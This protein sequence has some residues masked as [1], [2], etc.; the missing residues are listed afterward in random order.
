MTRNFFGKAVTFAA[1]AATVVVANSA[2]AQSRLNFV[3]SVNVS[4][5][6]A[7]GDVLLDFQNPILAVPTV[8]G[9]FLPE[10]V[11][12]LTLGTINDVEVG[13]GGCLNCPVSPFVTI[14]GYTFTLNSTPLAPAGPFNF[15]PIALTQTATGTT[16]SLSVRGTVT[17]GDFGATV[18]PFQ[19][20]FTAQ[21]T[22]ETPFEVFTSIDQGGTRNV[23][24]SAEFVVSAVPEPAT[25]ALMGTGLIAM[26][27]L[28][29]RRRTNV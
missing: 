26:F 24:F 6:N 9:V 29:Y 19:G 18:N 22:G 4:E 27:G 8:S 1:L 25:V 11:P 28:A 15:G 2:G 7:A 17:G 12:F 13:P 23:G 10:I 5:F 21:F 3:G 20:L 14:G 16:A